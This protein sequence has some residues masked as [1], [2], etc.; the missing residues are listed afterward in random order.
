MLSCL[1]SKPQSFYNHRA[2]PLLHARLL[3]DQ[4]TAQIAIMKIIL[5]FAKGGNQFVVRD[6][7]LSCE[8]SKPFRFKG[9]LAQSDLLTLL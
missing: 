4:P 8:S 1:I 9:A 5:H 3:F 6:S 2:F 7:F